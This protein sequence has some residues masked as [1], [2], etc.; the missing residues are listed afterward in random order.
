VNRGERG[1]VLLLALV[2]MALMNLAA[3][4]L[5]RAI[6]TTT[7]VAGNLAFR[8]AATALASA[9]I[10]DALASLF[11]S[12]AIAD[13]EHDLP[14]RGYYASWRPGEDSRSVPLVLQSAL[15]SASAV[16]ALDPSEGNV[17]RYVI[18]RLCATAGPATPSSC[19][20]AVPY[21]PAPSPPAEQPPPITPYTVYRVTARVDGPQGTAAYVQMMLRE[22]APPRRLSWRILGD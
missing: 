18:E 6:D 15:P 1:I 22:S 13:R 3:I 12:G 20:L 2:V 21:V 5:M 4:A 7:A 9:A 16:R 14:A 8:D 17:V 10:E 19:N 11:E